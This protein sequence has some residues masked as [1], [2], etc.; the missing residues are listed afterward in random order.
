MRSAMDEHL[1]AGGSVKGWKVVEQV[2]RR[3]WTVGDQEI[4]DYLEL[5]YDVP[6]DELRPRKLVTITDAKRL[7]KTY[8]G[9]GEYAEAERDMTLR[10][11]IKESKG[12]TTA[13]ESDRRAAISPVAA[14]FGDVQ[15]GSPED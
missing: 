7:L 2:G 9:K 4:T 14:S 13:P 11:T 10:F 12:L 1:L 3:A 15:L 8:V 6:G 5:M